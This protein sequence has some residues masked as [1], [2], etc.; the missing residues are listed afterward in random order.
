MRVFRQL[1]I[2]G[3]NIVFLFFLVLMGWMLHTAHIEGDLLIVFIVFSIVTVFP[4]YTFYIERLYKKIIPLK[5][6]DLYIQTVD[7]FLSLQ[8]FDDI[9]KVIFDKVLQYIGVKSGL[10]IFYSHDTDDYTIYYQKQQKQK[11]IR[12]AHIDK[13][14][15]IFRV[16]QSGDDVLI[17]SKMDPS[18]H[19]QRTILFEMEKLNGEI[20]IP[21]YYHDIFLGLMI[22][23]EMKRRISK[24]DILM[25]KAL[26]SKIATVTVNSFFMHELI[27][28]KE[29]EK[30]YELGYKVLKQ[31]MPPNEGIIQKTQY[32]MI[33]NKDSKRTH[34]FNIYN[35]DGLTSY[36]AVCPLQANISLL[37]LLIPALSVLLQSY[38]RL[39]FLPDNIIKK[40]N[41]VLKKKE[42]IEENLPLIIVK[43]KKRKYCIS[44]S[45]N[46]DLK[47]YS[48]KKTRI[49]PVNMHNKI[50]Q[51]NNVKKLI[52]TTGDM[53]YTIIEECAGYHNTTPL[54]FTLQE[55][56]FILVLKEIQ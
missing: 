36:I 14:N 50:T 45:L 16:I 43:K 48:Q 18:L 40:I 46:C 20:I 28:S 52:V 30:E 56:N 19:F 26:A 21:I 10:L 41:D 4:L 5:Y 44:K 6:E 31:F 55:D 24:R 29:I 35:P 12:K 34:Y 17:K 49:T 47:I 38:A 42:L 33:Q 8:S 13:N 51:I 25:L 3:I 2:Q 27:K 15:I 1:I 9:I 39:G 53:P 11:I 7:S 37:S 23:G 22:I 32:V 54:T